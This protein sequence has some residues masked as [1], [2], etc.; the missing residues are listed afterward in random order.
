M[1]TGQEKSGKD[2]EAEELDVVNQLP[3]LFYIFYIIDHII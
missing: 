3:E 2:W 1:P